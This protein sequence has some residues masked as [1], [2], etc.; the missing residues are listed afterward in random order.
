MK[1][2]LICAG[3]VGLLSFLSAARADEPVSAVLDKAIKALGGE[4]KL[5]AA[6][7]VTWASKGTIHLGD[8]EN[9]FTSSATAQGLDQYAGKFSG[10]FNGMPFEGVT[11]ID[12]SKGWRKFAEMTTELDE[13][14]LAME[15]R[16][17]YLRLVPTLIVPLKGP[18]FK[19]ESDGEEKEG[20]ITHNVVK[21]TATDGKDFRIYFDKESGLPVKVVATV[22]GFMGDESEQVMRL[23]DY[24]DFGGIMKATKLEVT[25]DGAPFV[26]ETV[27]EFK[28]HASVDAGAFKEP[29]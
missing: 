9:P 24:K 11:V 10:E 20:D 21:V 16:N 14:G 26:D 25:R 29:E 13:D 4:E 18:G 3:L 1:R 8:S 15:K 12:G 27:T 22:A 6:K 23:K 28:S 19:T 5:A 17:V 7:A 2:A